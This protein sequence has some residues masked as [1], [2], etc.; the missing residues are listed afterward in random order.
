MLLSSQLVQ[1]A[2]GRI[3][4][5]TR[6]TETDLRRAYS[7]LYYALFH[8]LCDTVASAVPMRPDFAPSREVYTALYRSVDHGTIERQCRDRKIDRFGPAMTKFAQQF[9]A[10]KDVRELAD[11]DP[12]AKFEIS[13]VRTAI[14]IAESVLAE[15]D[16]CGESERRSFAFYVAVRL[17]PRPTP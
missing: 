1:T 7:D 17:T 5:P 14:Q 9:I 12:L 13:S 10:F 15:F 11:Y 4:E 16:G 2:K 6:I 3:A 8:K